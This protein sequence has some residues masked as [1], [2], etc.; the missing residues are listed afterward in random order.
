VHLG[1]ADELKAA[2]QGKML[3]KM[4]KDANI[5]HLPFI[6]STTPSFSN[7]KDDG[8][9]LGTRNYANSGN[10]YGT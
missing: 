5:S 6:D 9:Y 4:L 2:A 8:K 3:N 10:M 1:G 7:D